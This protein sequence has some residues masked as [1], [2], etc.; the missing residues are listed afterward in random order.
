MVLDRS[1]LDGTD[2]LGGM[3]VA[4]QIMM[5]HVLEAHVRRGRVRENL[6]VDPGELTLILDNVTGWYGPDAIMG[7]WVSPY[8]GR[9]LLRAGVYVEF[10][11]TWGGTAYQMYRGYLSDLI[12]NYDT[13]VPTVTLV[14]VDALA[15]YFAR[16]YPTLPVPA[17]VG[18]SGGVRAARVA[19]SVGFGSLPLE[20]FN[21][22]NAFR[23]LMADPGGGVGKDILDLIAAGEG[24]RYYVDRFG[25]L[26]VLP[27]SDT[28]TRTQQL[29]LADNDI[30]ADAQIDT[31][32]VDPSLRSYANQ[33]RIQ[34]NQLIDVTATDPT[35]TL[36]MQPVEISVTT[37]LL[38]D[39]D[40]G[41]IATYY[42]THRSYPT[43][44]VATVTFE[45]LN[46]MTNWVGLMQCE[47][48]DRVM[49]KATYDITRTWLC[50]AEGI[51]HDILP[52]SWVVTFHSAPLDS[53]GAYTGQTTFTLDSL[54]N[55]DSINV[56][57]AF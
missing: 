5:T 40:T 44:R 3:W 57:G 47:L 56:L 7:P 24:G 13:P 35:S 51:L 37:A 34:R 31:L 21:I 30:N 8:D 20:T 49:I 53:V 16:S 48:G 2:T 11:G 25:A 32:T 43:P 46:N 52:E 6:T 27:H 28:Y 33:S 4:Q 26:T 41:Q 36:T 14:A 18:E 29:Y 19:A 9:T 17:Y 23:P 50:V 38:S 1:T 55:L 22:G 12:P 54:N 10:A 39:D 15:Q 45:A 42:A